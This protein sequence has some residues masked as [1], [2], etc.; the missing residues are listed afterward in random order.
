MSPA[1]ASSRGK[2]CEISFLTSTSPPSMQDMPRGQVSR[3]RLMNRK[4]ICRMRT[5]Q[6]VWCYGVMVLSSHEMSL[7]SASDRCMNG[8]LFITAL[9]TPTTIKHPPLRTANAAVHTLLSTPVHSST[10]LG[11]TYSPSPNSRLISLALS[12]APSFVFTWYVRHEGTRSCA[13]ASRLGSTSVMTMGCAPEA[14]AEARARRPM[15]PA[16]Q[17][18]VGV[19]SVRCA[20]SMPWSTTLRG[21]SRAPSAKETLSGSL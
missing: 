10:T 13:K 12:S 19:P 15:G 21:S 8:K 7:T 4:S 2:T 5:K 17:M 16:P 9:P 14:R 3:Y 18:R 20:D 1:T 11:C 6:S